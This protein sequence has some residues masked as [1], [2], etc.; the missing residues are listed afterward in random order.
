MLNQY[1][2]Q[3]YI[4]NLRR[5]KD[6]KE[7]TLNK[8]N[9]FNLQV[10]WFSAYDG[11]I[12]EPIW[13]SH[14]LQ[15]QNQHF[16]NPNYLACAMSHL[17][18]YQDAVDNGYQRILILED[19]NAFH[20]KLNEIWNHILPNLPLDWNQL[21]YLG[22]IPLTDDQQFW[23]YLILEDKIIN[24]FLFQAHNMW[25]LYA[26]GIHNN[27]M[28]EVLDTYQQF[29]YPM[30]LDRFFVTHIQPRGTSF[31]IT[32]QLFAATDGYS[33]NSG[34]NEIGML[35]RSIHGKWAQFSDYV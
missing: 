12:I 35:N 15:Y 20:G 14:Q 11:K 1:F 34:H 22:W 7:L 25:G 23:S 6:R 21:L 24:D 9:Q 18:I 3:I 33:D 28:K 8:L 17:G 16:K 13:K 19:D 10:D 26:Y 5:R 31:A 30:E 29:N 2:D 4:L 27:L 32:P